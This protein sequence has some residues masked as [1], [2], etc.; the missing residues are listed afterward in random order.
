MPKGALAAR[1]RFGPLPLGS[2]VDAVGHTPLLRL[3][4][5]DAPFASKIQIYAKL[6]WFNPGGSVKDRAARQMLLQAM[7][8]GDLRPSMTV[9]DSTSGNTGIAYAWLCAAL[10]L[11]CCLVMPENVSFG[12]KAYVRSLGAEIL[13]TDPLEGS[14]GAILRV[15]EIV[16]QHPGRYFYPDQYSNEANPLAHTLGTA[17][18]IWAQSEGKVSH[19][20]AGVGTSGTVIGTGRGLKAHNPKIQV[21]SLEPDDALHGLEGLKHL[22]SSIIPG[23]WK[24]DGVVDQRRSLLTED[25]FDM[26]DRL[27][28]EAGLALGPSGGAAAAGALQLAEELSAKGE[29]AWICTL[30]PDRADRYFSEAGVGSIAHG[31]SLC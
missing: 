3:K 15:K 13:W 10:G 20:V 29:E 1:Q 4:A 21:I 17:Q 14:D 28:K 9:I 18:E 22:E 19:F 16:R 8:A 2:L 6:E 23:I 24:P 5:L 12:R 30:F 7:E 26:V 25:A 11:K 27:M 31:L